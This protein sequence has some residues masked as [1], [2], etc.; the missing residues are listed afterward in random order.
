MMENMWVPEFYL[1]EIFHDK[2]ILKRV[3]ALP[4]G[5]G[6]PSVMWLEK[7]HSLMIKKIFLISFILKKSFVRFWR[8]LLK[9]S[10]ITLCQAIGGEFGRQIV[11]CVKVNADLSWN[12]LLSSASAVPGL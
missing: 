10:F 9:T 3:T 5:G 4:D 11:P 8:S 7:D 12:N 1:F 2:N 6:D